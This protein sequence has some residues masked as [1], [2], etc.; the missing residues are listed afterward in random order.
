MLD[1]E[2]MG[3]LGGSIFLGGYIVQIFRIIDLKSGRDVSY[4]MIFA[5][6]LATCGY[7]DFFAASNEI[8]LMDIAIAALGCIIL[9]ASLKYR[10]S[11][12]EQTPE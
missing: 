1:P 7:I 4:W 3:I 10:Y 9:M 11:R 2:L 6:G 8:I 5:F 12:N